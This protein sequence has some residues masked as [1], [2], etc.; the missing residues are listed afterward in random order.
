MAG[1]GQLA[2]TEANV[3]SLLRCWTCLSVRR[4]YWASARTAEVHR[5]GEGLLLTDTCA[6]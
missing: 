4:I 6:W 3:L 1:G 2:A 5:L